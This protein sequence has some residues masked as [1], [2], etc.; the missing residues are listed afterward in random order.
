M[1]R[2]RPLRGF[3][4]VELLVVIAIIGVLVALL[5]PAVQAA[6]ESARR[7]ACQN[8]LKQV[9]LALLSYEDVGK[10]LPVGC[11]GCREKPK[12][13]R[14]WCVDV[15]P[16]LEHGDLY[17]R[18]DLSLAVNDPVNLPSAAAVLG[19]FLCPSTPEGPQLAA[20]G[21]F[22]GAAYGDY[23]GLY[24]AEGP[25]ASAPFGAA[26][27]LADPYLGV[28]LYEQPTRFREITDGLSHTAA[29]AELLD[30]RSG[31]AEWANGA[32]LFAHELGQSV[33]EQTLLG[34]NVGGPHPGGAFL[35]FCDG[36]VAFIPNEL[37]PVLFT[38]L[39]TRAGGEQL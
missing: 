3:T 18:F 35:L 6:R 39:L 22:K 36:H 29:V 21:R 7:T 37:E 27:F 11:V 4:L 19:V 12:F 34:N 13:R 10:A 5:L 25:A 15:L 26:Q 20:D 17:D 32:T 31:D 2:R 30:R 38:A 23:G 33:N 16:H 14:S 8:N 1:A 9:G 24:G 28:M